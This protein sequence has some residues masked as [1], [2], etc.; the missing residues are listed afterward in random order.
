MSEA[1]KIIVIGNVKGGVGK[2]TIAT[3]ISIDFALGVEGVL[4]P[5]K[6]LLID[7]DDQ[8]SSTIFTNF[9]NEVTD[10]EAKYTAIQLKDSAIRT[11]T[12]EL[13]KSFDF[14]FIDVGGR[15]TA[16]LRNA[17]VIADLLLL[18]FL[19]R[20]LD[21][22]TVPKVEVLVSEAKPYNE[23][24]KVLSFINR[25]DDSGTMNNEAIEILKSLDY[26]K[27][28]DTPVGDRRA[29]GYATNAFKSVIEMNKNKK[30][31]KASNEM[32]ALYREILKELEA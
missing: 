22:W 15:D 9:R 10:G 29:F 3:N 31:I 12:P 19:P 24:L 26:L 11:Q 2:T 6:V 20:S 13:A 4:E 8:E 18:P 27:Y 1:G 17:V 25:L 32:K 14:I 30:D 7:G 5:K 16:S 21:V 28:I 23:D